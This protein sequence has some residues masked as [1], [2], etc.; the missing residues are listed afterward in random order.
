MSKFVIDSSSS[1]DTAN[2]QKSQFVDML[3]LFE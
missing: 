2:K 3:I 1:R